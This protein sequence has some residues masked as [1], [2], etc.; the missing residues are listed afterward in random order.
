[1][2]T[3]GWRFRAWRTDMALL[4][5]MFN[6]IALLLVQIIDLLTLITL[7]RTWRWPGERCYQLC[8]Q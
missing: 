8:N 7:L 3:L 5:T 1:M 6:H 4:A 2:E